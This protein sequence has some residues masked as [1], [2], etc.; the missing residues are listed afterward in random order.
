LVS[1]EVGRI[2]VALA[3]FDLSVQETQHFAKS[4]HIAVVETVGRVVVY[5]IICLTMTGIVQGSNM[6]IPTKGT[7]KKNT[8]QFEKE[9]KDAQFYD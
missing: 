2:P 3:L 6:T 7:T 4:F 9:T 1:F 5:E 8:R